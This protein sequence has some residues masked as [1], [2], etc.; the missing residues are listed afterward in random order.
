MFIQG[1]CLSHL[2][3]GMNV[4]RGLITREFINKTP[5]D[6]TLHTHIPLRW[7]EDTRSEDRQTPSSHWI[8]CYSTASPS[9]QC[10]R[11]K[12]TKG[13]RVECHFIFNVRNESLREKFHTRHHNVEPTLRV[14]PRAFKARKVGIQ[15]G[16][17]GRRVWLT[18]LP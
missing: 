1:L 13:R 3:E 4:W 5:S 2:P 15:H 9:P 12:K 6:N 16:W 11:K 7:E 17:C 10:A 18:S 8:K 14:Y